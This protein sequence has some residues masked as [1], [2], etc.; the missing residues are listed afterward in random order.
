MYATW[1][2]GSTKRRG[3][4]LLYGRAVTACRVLQA[5]AL[6]SRPVALFLRLASAEGN[7]EENKRSPPTEQP[8]PTTAKA[9]NQTT[10][11]LV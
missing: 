3:L 11:R 6:C 5:V 1:V 2:L 7:K 8:R 4:F 9:N 10:S